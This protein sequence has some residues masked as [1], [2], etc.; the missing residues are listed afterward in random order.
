MILVMRVFQQKYLL[1]SHVASP[2]VFVS[3]LVESSVVNFLVK[4]AADPLSHT[5][6]L[7]RFERAFRTKSPL[8]VADFLVGSQ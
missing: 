1:A 3:R 8:N 2:V 7:G 5:D 6:E 4:F